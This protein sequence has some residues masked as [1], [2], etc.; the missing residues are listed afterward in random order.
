MALLRSPFRTYT[1][2]FYNTTPLHTLNNKYT[3]ALLAL[4]AVGVGGAVVYYKSATLHGS[5]T[6]Q[7]KA[8][9]YPWSHKMPWQAFDHA[10]IRRGHKVY[11]Q[12]C[13]NCHSLNLIAYRNLVDVCYTEEEA[14][15]VAAELEFKDGPNEDGDMFDRPGRL[16]DYM[17]KPYDNEKQGRAANNGAFPVDLSLII[18]ARPGHEDYLFA[19]LTGYREPP[20]GI[21]MR[22][23]TNY[24]PYF[25]G[26]LISM[27]QA[28]TANMVEYDDGTESSISQMAKDVAT[29]LCWAAEPEHDDR[30]RLTFKIIFVTLCLTFASYYA[31][32]FYWSVVKTAV[33]KFPK[34]KSF[35]R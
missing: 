7:L 22:A 5:A 12:V 20:A 32:K 34:G 31:K 21:V 16:T 14:K 6:A 1:R 18:K 26:G 13:S 33:L 8:A 3:K 27:P 19:L 25:P 23:G 11:N 15:V 17:P 28:L 2:R 9:Q 35:Y 24:N 4:G 29:F 30:K 10:S